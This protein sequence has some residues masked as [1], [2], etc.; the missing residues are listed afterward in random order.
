M[1]FQLDTLD[2]YINYSIDWI[3]KFSNDEKEVLRL[4][5]FFN[6]IYK[7][8][9]ILSRDLIFTYNR[10]VQDYGLARIIVYID[11][12]YHFKNFH[13]ISEETNRDLNESLSGLSIT[14]K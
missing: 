13:G 2:E 11:E 5:E 3:D 10:G 6:T 1:L 7:I 4:N 8:K 9:K 12:L 14:L